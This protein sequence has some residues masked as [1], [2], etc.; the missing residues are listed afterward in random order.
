MRSGPTEALKLS[1]ILRTQHRVDRSE[2]WLLASELGI[3]PTG[4]TGVL[5]CWAERRWDAFVEHVVP[6]DIP[7]ERVR[8]DLLGVCRA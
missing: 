7:E 2:G 3:E 1:L 8:L 5:E 6:V 4:I